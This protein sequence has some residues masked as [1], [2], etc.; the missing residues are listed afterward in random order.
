MLSRLIYSRHSGQKKDDEILSGG[1]GRSVD[2][3][4]SGSNT[5]S[6]PGSPFDSTRNTTGSETHGLSEPYSSG[7]P[8]G[9]DDDAATTASVKSGIP[10][11]SQ[12]GNALSGSNEPSLNTN[13]ALPREPATAHSGTT[14]FGN[15]THHGVGSGLT[16][17]NLPDR[18]V[19]RSVAISLSLLTWG[20]KADSI[21]V[22][23]SVTATLAHP[24]SKTLAAHFLSEVVLAVLIPT[25]TYHTLLSLP[26]RQILVSNLEAPLLARATGQ[27]LVLRLVPNTKAL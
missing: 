7:M 27:E 25:L 1:G 23:N 2:P 18:S 15:T 12:T 17:T 19:G 11:T 21:I 20:T 6:G 3:L 8:G 13:K 14:G 4:P 24:I 10:G 5:A 16:G 9:F 22:L 26:T